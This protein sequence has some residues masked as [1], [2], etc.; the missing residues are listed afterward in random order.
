MHPNNGD[1]AI[2]IYS[3][4]AIPPLLEVTFMRRAEL[5]SILK[6]NRHEDFLAYAVND[7][8]F[9]RQVRASWLEK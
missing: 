6:K 3:R 4:R 1:V 7:K 2:P 8:R 9:Q 5:H